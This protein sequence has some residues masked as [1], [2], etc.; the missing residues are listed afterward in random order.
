MCGIVG[1]VGKK[2]ATP[3]LLDGLHALEYRGYDSAGLYVAGKG[4][5]KRAGKVA[6]LTAAVPSDFYGTA[7]IAHTRW[8]THGAPTETNAHPHTDE[9]G[10]VWLVHNG[11]IENYAELAA[12]LHAGGATFK[13]ETDSE[14]LAALVG[15]EVRAGQTLEDA[16]ACALSRVRGT[17]GLAVMSVTE[18]EKIVVARLGSPLLIGVAHGARFVA[19]DAT[20]LL[21][22][23][24][25]VVYLEDGDLAVLTPDAHVVHRLDGGTATRASAHLDWSVEAAEKNGQEHFMLKEMLEIPETIERALAGRLGK[26]GTVTLG[27][28]KD[29]RA[30]LRGARRIVLTGCG[31]AAYSAQIG[32]TL[33]ER[34]AGIP[35]EVVLASELRYRPFLID[36]KDT[37]LI[38]VSQSGETLDTLEAVREAKR[39][40]VPTLGIVNVV[41][42]TI[43]RETD[44]SIYLHAGPEISVA[45]T[46]A[47][48]GQATVLALLA[49]SLA[50]THDQT[51]DETRAFARELGRSPSLAR[52]TLSARDSIATLAQKYANVSGAFF[53]GRGA[54]T[55]IAFEGALKLKEVSY[56]HAEGYPAGE[57][58]H[59]PIALLDPEFLVVALAP[60]DALFEKMRSNLQEAAA[61]GCRTIAVTTPEHQEELARLADDVIVIPKTHEALLPFLTVLP[62]QL[63]AYE[64]AKARG[65]HI[66]QPRNLAKSV[67]VE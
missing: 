58:K 43:S 21:P 8:A 62:L 53:L 67:T 50:E 59:G 39:H 48:I 28:V 40:G 5:V 24:R 16:V 36:P 47:F 30:P 14:V 57:M 1:Y 19:S 6:A 51:N 3:F 22:H 42:S 56:I 61:R 49:L 17:Y 20:P 7:G 33:I 32:A 65:C 34:F 45:T 60:G 38:A 4:A 55:P 23:T 26:D 29:M 37:V 64:V 66:D 12:E 46:K 10:S 31:S 2:N 25:E 9:G 27:G 35:C 54:E 13:T 15:K 52:A 63:F 41:G 18:P 44:A 11:I